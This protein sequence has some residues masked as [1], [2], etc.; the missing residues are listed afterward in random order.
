MNIWLRGVDIAFPQRVGSGGMIKRVSDG[1]D[2]ADIRQF[3]VV[4]IKASQ[5][6]PNGSFKDPQFDNSYAMARKF[7]KKVVA[8][9]FNDAR[10]SITAQVDFFLKTASSVDAYA[11]DQ[12]GEFGFTDAQ[13]QAFV[14]GMRARQKFIGNYHSASGFEG[15]DADFEWV[16]DYRLESL[17]DGFTPVVG[18]DVWQFSSEGGPD[19]AG[20]DLNWLPPGSELAAFLGLN[21]QAIIDEQAATIAA[22]LT[23]LREAQDALSQ[24]QTINLQL[25]GT[26]QLLEEDKRKLTDD[27]AVAASNERNRIAQKYAEREAAIIRNL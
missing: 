1:K 3:D 15:V 18:Y 14:D 2:L 9:H 24:A 19:G 20:L 5:G 27:L 26:I 4:F 13:T 10:E 17:Q 23:E 21:P 6:H 16:A 25:Q 8:Y 22:K 7:G 11:I 12:E